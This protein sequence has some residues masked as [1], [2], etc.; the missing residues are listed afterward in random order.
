[1]RGIQQTEKRIHYRKDV[2]QDW[3]NKYTWLEAEEINQEIFIFCKVCRSENKISK[4]AKGTN[5]FRSDQI[6]N[7]PNTIEHKDSEL[8]LLDSERNETDRNNKGSSVILLIRIIYFCSKQNI[9]LDTYP[10]LCDLMSLQIENNISDK[11]STLKPASI[12]KLLT[13]K[14]KYGS[15]TNAHSALDFLDSITSI[16]KK[17]LFEELNSSDYWS[18][19]IDE[20]NSIDNNKYLA[21]VGKYIVNNIPYLRYLGMINLK[22]TTAENI[23]NQILSFCISNEIS[24]H[25]IIH[26]GSDGASNMI[27]NKTGVATR[28]KKINPFMSSIHCI[29]HRLHLAGKDA[30]DEIEYFQEY[31]KVLRS[32]YSYFS[33]SHKRQNLLKLMQEIN[34]EP[35]LKVL[36]LCDTRWLSLSNSVHNLH[37]IMNSVV[38]ALNDDILEGD[39]HASILFGQLD[40]DF[41][42]ATMF[43]ADLTNILKKSIK[44]FQLDNLTL[45]QYKPKIN[46]TIKEITEAFI[47]D[48]EVPP[49]YGII[50]KNYLERNS[51]PVPSFVKD[52]SLAMIRAI[53]DRFPDSELFSSFKIFNP[54]ELPDNENDLDLYGKEEIEFL[55][56]FYGNIKQMDGEEYEIVEKGKLIEEWSSLKFYLQSCKNMEMNFIELWKHIFDTDDDFPFNYPNSMII[57]KIALLIPFSNAHIE[58]IF[59][60]MKLIKNKLRNKMNINTLNNHLMILLNGPDI[61]NFDFEKAYEHWENKKGRRRCY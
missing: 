56:E 2:N 29:S 33:K 14:S 54:N 42:T 13:S 1:M 19:M 3:F 15:H 45:S 58:R 4:L 21:I 60:D 23:Y 25:K 52:Y 51:C 8:I 59:S 47:G 9:S 11:V 34:N 48:G 31:E 32:L 16:I 41:I 57:V 35:T 55:E 49:S 37:Q 24:Y 50:F 12:E 30:S 26:F 5:V 7:H 22:S 38:D 20:T 36:K 39:E 17:S 61:Q 28:L 44:I 10:D 27:G 18:I 40:H 6:A 43:L 46:A 53:N